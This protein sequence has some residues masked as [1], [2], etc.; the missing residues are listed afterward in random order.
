MRD[1]PLIDGELVESNLGQATA[2]LQM[3]YLIGHRCQLRFLALLKFELEF[4]PVKVDPF[5]GR[6]TL[7]SFHVYNILQRIFIS[8]ILNFSE[9]EGRG[10]FDQD[11]RIL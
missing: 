3:I 7:A 4:E 10:T 11:S 1:L 8:M 5:L 6:S 2:F 9:L